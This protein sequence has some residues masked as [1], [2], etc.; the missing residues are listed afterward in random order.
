M[1]CSKCGKNIAD[2]TRFCVNCGNRLYNDQEQPIQNTTN[3][4]QQAATK[5]K[6]N[7]M[8]L[9]GFIL[10]CISFISVNIEVISK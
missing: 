5:T 8:A 2:N 10:G 6:L 9:V 3:T 4:Y 7:V 1:F